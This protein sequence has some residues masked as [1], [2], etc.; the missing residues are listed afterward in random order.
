M[1]VNL[2]HPER[3]QQQVEVTNPKLE[4]I[5]QHL[6]SKSHHN[7]THYHSANKMATAD[8]HKRLKVDHTPQQ[9]T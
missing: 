5:K 1:N 6:H 9:I 7:H 2:A 3:N 4:G 8:T